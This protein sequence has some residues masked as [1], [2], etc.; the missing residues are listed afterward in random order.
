MGKRI[1]LISNLKQLELE[2]IDNL[3]I[4]SDVNMCKFSY[5]INDDMRE[6][7]DTLPYHFTIFGTDKDNQEEFIKLIE[8][9]KMGKFIV[10]VSSVEIMPGNDDSYV[11]YLGIENNEKLKEL[12]R[13]IRTKFPS[14]YYNPDNFKFHITIDIDKDYQKIKKLQSEILK[15][16]EPFDIEIDELALYDYPGS[17]IRKFNLL[18]K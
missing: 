18:E 3:L 1:T 2:K 15:M 17:E 7:L 8:T 9:I 13:T 10:K 4:D 12:Q 6:L 16:F 5:G 14:K 11:L